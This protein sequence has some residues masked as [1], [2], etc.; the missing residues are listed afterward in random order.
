MGQL[1]VAFWNVQNLFGPGA[2]PRGPQSVDEFDDKIAALCAVMNGFFDGA[3]PDLLG[4]AEAASGAIVNR[5]AGALV[6][7]YTTVWEPA[8]SAANTG[9]ALLGRTSVF[10][11]IHRVESYRPTTF[12]R[13]R[14]LAVRCETHGV[15][16]PF[17]AVV[18]HWKSRM[19]PAH[20]AANDRIQAARELG[21]FLARQ[22][23]HACAIVF[24][25][26]NAEPFEPPFADTALRARRTF[27]GAL[28]RR[29]TPAY[30]YNTAWR[31]LAEP[32]MWEAAGQPGYQEPRP[33]T[34]HGIQRPVVFDQ[35]LVSGRALQNGPIRLREASIEYLW[36]QATSRR[37]NRG[38]LQPF[39]WKWRSARDFEG[40]SDHFP[41]LARFD[42]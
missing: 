8:G 24:G 33:K 14:W 18:N 31:F 27:A 35:L 40:V 15:S 13:P 26:F 9:L 11:R 32:E 19:P 2:V 6:G 5:L 23:R 36:D 21:D 20:I 3:G 38:E 4:I 16:E 25:D 29:A 12:A 30:L 39:A 22:Q 7:P 17:L 34:T 41:L 10:G 42:F 1:K 28:W 37:N